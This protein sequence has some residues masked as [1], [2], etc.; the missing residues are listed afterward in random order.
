MTISPGVRRRLKDLSFMVALVAGSLAARSSLADHYHVPT[1]SM[2]PTVEIGDRVVVNK[3]AYGVRLPLTSGY[4]VEGADP[5]RGEVIVL[6]SPEDGTTVLLKRIAGVP[7]DTV[8]LRDRSV[9]VV[10]AGHY[11]VMGDNRGNS[12]DGRDFGFVAR[13]AILGR[14]HHVGLRD[15]RPVWVP[16]D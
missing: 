4:L 6:R 1:G 2:I 13:D 16:L 10:P 9:V 5:R 12:H 15:S 8:T 14:A 7:G 11:F 3:L